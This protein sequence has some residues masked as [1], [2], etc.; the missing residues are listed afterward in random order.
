M[1]LNS[2]SRAAFVLVLAAASTG[3]YARD[4]KITLPKSSSPT[5]VQRLNQ[6][7]VK[8]INQHN[9]K[10]AEKL[11]YRAY[12]ID[13]TDPF[14]LNNLGYISELNGQVD[15]AL[16]FYQLASATESD[17][18]IYK[19]SVPELKGKKLT[20]VTSNFENR[21]L[22]INRA[23]IEAMSLLQSGR[24]IEAENALK[25]ALDIQPNNPFTINNLG[26]TMEAEGDL[27]SALQYYQKAASL[28]STEKIIVTPDPHWRGRAVSEI[29]ANNASALQ[30]RIETE[31]SVPAQV[32]RLNLQ[33]VFALNHN[34]R[35]Q[36][37][38]L[39]EQAFKLDPNNAFSLNNMGYVSEMNGDR[40]TAQEYYEA[41]RRAQDARAK[42]TVANRPEVVGQALTQ[43]ASD[44][45]QSTENAMET[46]RQVRQKQ[47]G[48]I[49]LKRRD[50]TPVIEPATP[51]QTNPNGTPNP[52][53]PTAPQ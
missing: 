13:P 9:F 23:N 24:T 11:F 8:A 38:Q 22:R 18:T 42:V 10:K 41:A 16:K 26:Y 1:S 40:E 51:P 32:A 5:P 30:R 35:D 25:K 29:A 17:T 44:N 34:Q 45:S 21:D 12:L 48:P 14:T 6:D 15:R 50:N 52:P 49:Q 53:P 7:G 3:A 43:V 39:F 27:Q 19:A 2:F 28:N 47:G 4:V 36:A 31:Q 33:G 46:N 20:S 37:R